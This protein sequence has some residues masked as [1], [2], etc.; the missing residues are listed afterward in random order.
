MNGCNARQSLDGC[1]VKENGI[2]R[3]YLS[4]HCSTKSENLSKIQNAF[5]KFLSEIY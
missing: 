3:E 1:V 4:V 2:A 5:D